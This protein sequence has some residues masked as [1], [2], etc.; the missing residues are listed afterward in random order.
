MELKDFLE[1][2]P[3]LNKSKLSELMYPGVKA[4]SS[5]LANKLAERIVGSG[6][7]RVLESDTQAAVKALT[8]VRE[9]ID[10]F[11]EANKK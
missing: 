3:I 11:I 10:E 8:E 2:N 5:K 7:Q 6:K 1:N 9:K 4:T